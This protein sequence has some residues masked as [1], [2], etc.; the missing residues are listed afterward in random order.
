MTK[1]QERSF[2]IAGFL[3][4][5]ALLAGGGTGVIYVSLWCWAMIGVG[6]PILLAV[7]TAL[8]E[9]L[10]RP[11]EENGDFRILSTSVV[12]DE[13]DRVICQAEDILRGYEQVQETQSSRM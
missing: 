2:I 13:A 12:L 9:H 8:P 4:A 5:I 7:L 11:R 6:V 1:E 10:I 3:V